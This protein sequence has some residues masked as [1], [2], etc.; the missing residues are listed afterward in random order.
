MIQI[1][2][3]LN[4][5]SLFCFL[6]SPFFD[7][8]LSAA[9]LLVIIFL[10]FP[11]FLTSVDFSC[12]I[13][14]DKAGDYE[15]TVSYA[16]PLSKNYFVENT[17]VLKETFTNT[18]FKQIK[19]TF[20]NSMVT[21]VR[22]SLPGDHEYKVKN[23]QLKGY[24]KYKL[25]GSQSDVILC[26]PNCLK[27]FE[28]AEATLK[29]DTDTKLINFKLQNDPI[30]IYTNPWMLLAFFIV[31]ALVMEGLSLIILK[32]CGTFFRW[33]WAVLP[34]YLVYVV[35][36]ELA[37]NKDIARVYRTEFSEGSINVIHE[38]GLFF[39]ILTAILVAISWSRKYLIRIPA[40]LAFLAFFVINIVDFFLIKELN[41]RLAINSVNNFGFD[42]TAGLPMIYDF[43]QC[44]L[45]TF[46]VIQFVI[47][48]RFTFLEYYRSGLNYGVVSA[49]LA[50][51]ILL[52]LFTWVMPTPGSTIN[53][54]DFANVIKLNSTTEKNPY[55]KDYKFANFVPETKTYPGKNTKQNVIIID[56]ESFSLYQS[57]FFGGFYNNMPNMDKLASQY[58]SFTNY[59]STGFASDISNFAI[60]TGR[61]YINGTR[62]LIDPDF[63]K[64]ALPV[65]F[66]NAG[67]KTT[68]MYSS[69]NVFDADALLKVAGFQNF[70]DGKDKHYQ[71]SERLTFNAVPDRD[72]FDNLFQEVSSWKTGE[73]P[74]FTMVLTATTHAPFIM[75]VTH[76]GSYPATMRYT[77]KQIKNLVDRLM[78]IKYFDHGILVLVADH[79]VML[80]LTY[81]ELTKYG[82]RALA[83]IPL[84][85]V[86]PRLGHK[87]FNNSVAHD[88]LGSII[89]YLTLAETTVSD[90]QC[91][92]FVVADCQE[93]V[94]YQKKGPEDEVLV[95]KGDGTNATV[96]LNG[97]DS[98]VV[99]KED[100]DFL[101]HIYWFRK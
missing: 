15:I 24:N 98:S 77:D 75:P 44:T 71:L 11:H 33:I 101:K 47:F 67:Y 8:L 83:K 97:D 78:S 87:V 96:K 53:D 64:D 56:L 80:S 22:I 6:S 57:L 66:N 50:V 46:F 38:F 93:N 89:S 99:P 69:R 92:P 40:F 28:N 55:S 42:I 31:L 13:S 63:Y 23:Y 30:L 59:Y 39:L 58:I 9:L 68:V 12:E 43:M 48:I 27:S 72:L 91:N 10:T 17:T 95:F 36:L 1:L 18:D 32:Y 7:G 76:I 94:Y 82:D 84:V 51:T 45:F 52:S 54:Y 90:Y 35:I 29:A 62:K 26:E 14:P 86:A 4:R 65:K 41:A 60:L 19:L 25:Q 100:E 34:S 20:P 73:Q 88:S 3:Y 61:P 37:F 21:N 5:K 79:R 74:F 2:K 16:T 81:D 85:I 70:I 49:A